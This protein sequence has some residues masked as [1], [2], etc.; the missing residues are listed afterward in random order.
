MTGQMWAIPQ[1]LGELMAT[2]WFDL[3]GLNSNMDC[4]GAQRRSTETG[5]RQSA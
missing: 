1:C 3:Y 4:H 2:I 5:G